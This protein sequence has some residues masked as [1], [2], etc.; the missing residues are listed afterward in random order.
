MKNTMSVE[1]GC[2]LTAES[3]SRGHYKQGRLSEKHLAFVRSSLGPSD[4]NEE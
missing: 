3:L 1:T 2:R 4:L